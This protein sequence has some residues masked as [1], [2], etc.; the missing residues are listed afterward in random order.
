MIY[1]KIH[2]RAVNGEDF[3]ISF[4]EINTCCQNQGISN[5]IFVMDNA[6]I[7]Q[8]RGLDNDEEI[9]LYQ[10]KYLPPY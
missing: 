8:Y 9:A 4:K 6:R 10:L 3:K 2:E 5:P 1:H 7:Y